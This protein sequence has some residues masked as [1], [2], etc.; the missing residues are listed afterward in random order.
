LR[1]LKSKNAWGVKHRPK[2]RPIFNQD[3]I[4]ARPDATIVVCEGKKD[5]R[6]AALVF[7]DCVTTTSCGG[8][9]SANIADWSL[10]AGRKILLW[11]HYDPGGASYAND[12]ARSLFDLGCEILLVDAANVASLKEGGLKYDAADAVKDWMGARVRRYAIA[13]HMSSLHTIDGRQ[14]YVLPDGRALGA[15]GGDRIILANEEAPKSYKTIGSLDDWRN[16]VAHMAKDHKMLAL[17]IAGSFAGALLGLLGIEGGGVH[18]TA[19]LRKANPPSYTWP[20]CLG[21]RGA[22]VARN[23]ELPGGRSGERQ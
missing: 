22:P 19:Y 3:K 5:A 17:A 18:S 7:T 9:Q 6:A 14:V 20:L 21:L 16:G 4:A 2:P 23:S 13:V 12:A 8:A 15:G 1:W 11:P 10:V